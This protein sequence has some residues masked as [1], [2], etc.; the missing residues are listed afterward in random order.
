ML[1]NILDMT[2]E[3]KQE[4]ITS[5]DPN[6]F[7]ILIDDKDSEIRISIAAFGGKIP[8]DVQEKLLKDKL[9]EVRFEIKCKLGII[10]EI[11]NS[12]DHDNLNSL[13]FLEICKKYNV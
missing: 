8:E 1:K 2:R 7:R 6:I 9:I 13:S 3:E 5:G 11:N 10:S 4:L 12:T